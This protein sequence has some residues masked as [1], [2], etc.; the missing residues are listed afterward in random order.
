MIKTIKS[1]GYRLLD[2]FEADFGQLT[3]VIGANATGKSTLIDLIQLISQSTE[4]P[5]KDVINWHGGMF[6]L[7]TARPG[8]KQV[9]WTI[10]FEKPKLNAAWREV[11][12]PDDRI[13]AYEVRLRADR[14]GLP[15]SDYECLRNAEP[16]RGHGQPLKYL[17]A[18]PD[19]SMI[20][21]ARKKKLMPFDEQPP[22]TGEIN[23]A[24]HSPAPPN[25]SQ[26]SGVQPPQQDRSLSLARMRFHNDYPIQSWIRTLL[27]SFGFYPGFDVGKGSAVRTK[28]AE[29]RPEITLWPSGENLGTVLHEVLT[30]YEF[31][32]AADE[33]RD[34]LRAAYPWFEDISAETAFGSPAK[35]LVRLRERDV[36]RAVELWDLSD[37]VLRFLC[38]TAALLNPNPPPVV[39]VDEPELGF[40]PKLLPLVADLLKRAADQSQVIIT[41]HSPDLLN[42][43]EVDDVAVM[44]RDGP[45]ALWHRPASRS[46]LKALLESVTTESLGDLHRSGE[47]EA[48]S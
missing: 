18:T 33:I 8:D 10:T 29:I 31:R 34:F 37:G 1:N 5:L 38:L 45:K 4:F 30:R 36:Q 44:A 22:Q 23:D 9:E 20:F 32:S 15:A 2:D 42:R 11:P 39:A 14:Y 21:D 35:V 27:G 41:T 46:G 24:A 7:P 26:V 48:M 12:I 17:E 3:V 28:P 43:F 25:A 40:H 47:L 19:R 13:F 16:Y 6:S